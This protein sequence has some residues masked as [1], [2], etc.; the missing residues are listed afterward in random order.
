[1]NTK[2]L[3]VAIASVISPGET[4]DYYEELIKLVSE[5][6]KIPIE[7]KQ[8]KTYTEVNQLLEFKQVDLAFIC[9]GAYVDLA[10]KSRIEILVVPVSN[11]KPFYQSYIITNSNTSINKFEDLKDKSFAFTDPLSNTGRLYA[12]K[13]VKESGSDVNT[14][15]SKWMYTYAHDNSIQLVQRN[16]VDAAS[17]DG[18]VFEYLKKFTPEKVENIRIIEKSEYFGIPP[19][20]VPSLLDKEIKD[21]LRTLFLE[22]DKDPVGKKILDKLLI[23]KFI[24][25][26][27]SDYDSIREMIKIY[28]K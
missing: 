24:T 9:S 19:I 4:F 17:V 22:L 21:K 16:T 2:L 28:G 7:F 18:L 1:L 27:D 13:R 23:D 10:D 5:K 25:G 14:F 8:R 26:K 6:I 12:V 20:V 15:F 3:R 11:G